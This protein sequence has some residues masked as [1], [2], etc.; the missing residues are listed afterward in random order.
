MANGSFQVFRRLRQD[1]M[2]FWNQVQLEHG[3]LL[4]AFPHTSIS[5][6][7]L[8]AKL[9]G[10]WKSGTPLTRGDDSDP[11]T[12]DPQPNKF[13]YSSPGSDAI[14][15]FAHIRK[16]NPRSDDPRFRSRHH[17]ILRRGLPYGPSRDLPLKPGEDRG[18]LFNAF[19]AC[20]ENQFEFLQT[21]WSNNRNV[22]ELGTGADPVSANL[23]TPSP[24]TLSVGASNCPLDFGS[25]VTVT[26]AVYA[27]VPSRSAITQLVDGAL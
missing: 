23:K 12:L 20:V 21:E 6:D 27:F 14:P 4:K 15:E 3:N 7:L 13:N 11:G 19:M 16:L 17:R 5:Q 18:L 25:F 2:G 9:V 26:G 1:V 10:R 8:G 24:V 22:S